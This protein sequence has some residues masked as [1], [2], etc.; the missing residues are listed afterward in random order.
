MEKK[1]GDMM[2]RVAKI[3]VGRLNGQRLVPE[4][5]REIWKHALGPADPVFIPESLV[6][7]RMIR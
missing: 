7:K 2:A 1:S 3:I 4:S 6:L 5:K